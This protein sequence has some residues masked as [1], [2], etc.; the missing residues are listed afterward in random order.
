MSRVIQDDNLLL[1]EA[2]VSGSRRGFPEDPIIIFR[3]VS[4]RALRSRSIQLDGDVADA[5]RVLVTA[6]DEQVGVWF[7][8]A[9][10]IS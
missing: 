5:E 10:E 8:S 7:R 3:C 4:D 9:E 6:T 1:W 2:Y